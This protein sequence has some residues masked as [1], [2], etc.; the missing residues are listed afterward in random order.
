[1]INQ[2]FYKTFCSN[3]KYALGA[4]SCVFSRLNAP[5]CLFSEDVFHITTDGENDQELETRK[6]DGFRLIGL[7][8]YPFLS[9]RA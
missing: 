9:G 8:I 7:W 3:K 1:M 6:N 4:K 5:T 2:C